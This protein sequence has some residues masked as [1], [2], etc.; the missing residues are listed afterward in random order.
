MFELSFFLQA[1]G[2]SGLGNLVF[3]GA[4]IAVFYLFMLRPQIKKQ[5][6]QTEFSIALKKGDEVVTN[7][8]IIGK[9]N[10]MEDNYV[11]LESSK[12]FIKVLKTAVS[13]EMTEQLHPKPAEKK[14]GIFGL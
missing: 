12:S 11:I 8:G 9:I 14:K 4:I 1:G 5:K 6:Q 3:F 7:S 2:P 13:K 10:K